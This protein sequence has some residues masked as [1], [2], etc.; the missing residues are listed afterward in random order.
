MA[1]AFVST[2]RE[3]ART[4]GRFGIGLKTLRRLGTTLSVHCGPYHASISGNHV[5]VAPPAPAI[6]GFY[7]PGFRQTLLELEPNERASGISSSTSCS[8]VV[9]SVSGSSRR[10]FVEH[11][12]DDDRI[13]RRSRPRRPAG[14]P[15]RS[16]RRC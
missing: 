3:E 16:P 1:L 8:R 7:R 12:R 11:G 9:S 10:R 5:D 2:K 13:E 4:K 14:R 15:R 6:E